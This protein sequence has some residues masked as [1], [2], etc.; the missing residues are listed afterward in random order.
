MSNTPEPFDQSNID[1]AVEQFQNSGLEPAEALLAAVKLMVD[2]LAQFQSAAPAFMDRVGEERTRQFATEEF[3]DIV[4]EIQD[5]VP[6]AVR[7][8]NKLMRGKDAAG[9]PGGSP[10]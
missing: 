3:N 10:A 9:G 8:F 1:K 5:S 7:V 6:V 4:Y 2:A